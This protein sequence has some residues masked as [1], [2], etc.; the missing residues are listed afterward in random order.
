MFDHASL[1]K[2]CLML[3]AVFV[4]AS[5]VCPCSI[6]PGWPAARGQDAPGPRP[7]SSPE[8]CNTGDWLQNING[9][10]AGIVMDT[11]FFV[12]FLFV[13]ILWCLREQ[14]SAPSPPCN[15]TDCRGEHP[16]QYPVDLT[17]KM[18]LCDH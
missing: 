16:V 12:H 5:L 1:G 18:H 9:V 10:P 2:I 8:L 11:W 17:W 7:H 15:Y 13:E 4:W 14:S 3:F 6:G